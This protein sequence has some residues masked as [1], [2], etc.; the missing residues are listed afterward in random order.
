MVRKSTI[1]M[2]LVSMRRMCLLLVF[3]L[4]S[5]CGYHYDAGGQKKLLP[6]PLLDLPYQ[7]SGKVQHVWLGDQFQMADDE[8]AHY[9]ILQGVERPDSLQRHRDMAYDKLTSLLTGVVI[10]V[11]V[12]QRDDSERAVGRVYVGDKDVNLEMILTGYGRY[13]GTVFE[14][15]DAFAAAEAQAKKQK[16][17]IWNELNE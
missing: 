15:S 2:S 5:S 7:L 3:L 10:D 4:L 9:I 16:L 12:D 14:G 8:R 1:S 13:D 17:G 6:S 11:N